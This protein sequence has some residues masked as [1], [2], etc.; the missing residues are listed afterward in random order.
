MKKGKLI[1]ISGPSG[2]GKGSIRDKIT[3]DFPGLFFS[4]SMTTRAPRKGEKNGRE[5]LFV[6]NREFEKKI[7]ENQL[8]EYARVYDHY[9]GTDREWVEIK[10][11][12][13]K[14]VILEI[15]VQ[16]AMQVKKIYPEAV[17]IFVKPPSIGELR[18]RI[19]ER[20]TE[21]E[22]DIAARLK[23]ATKEIEWAKEYDYCVINDNLAKATA[24]VKA[25]MEEELK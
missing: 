22:A 5:Y 1:V 10:L 24:K 8:L 12:E 18:K 15:D 25:I 9:Y 23:E 16:G 21:T 7:N 3:Q 20:G 4:V 19:L 17:T 13:G 6:T 14:N 2:A 11:N